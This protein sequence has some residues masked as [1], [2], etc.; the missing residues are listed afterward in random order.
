MW[1]GKMFSALMARDTLSGFVKWDL[2]FCTCHLTE[3]AA[4]GIPYWG[5]FT[6][7]SKL[8]T[9]CLQ[10]FVKPPFLQHPVSRVLPRCTLIWH[11]ISNRKLCLLF[12]LVCI[13][14]SET[15][16]VSFWSR[17][18]KRHVEKDTKMVCTK[19]SEAT[20]VIH[21]VH[22]RWHHNIV[23]HW[24]QRFNQGTEHLHLASTSSPTCT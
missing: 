8:Y 19:I 4:V 16:C 2:A 17:K 23:P 11:L 13:T 10:Q 5:H 6:F 22:A 24:T 21:Q 14:V 20:A 15:S 3:L 9:W 12:A 1:K 7:N 18:K